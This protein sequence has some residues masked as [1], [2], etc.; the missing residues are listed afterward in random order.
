[1]CYSAVTL[2]QISVILVLSITGHEKNMKILIYLFD[3]AK[4][5]ST[6]IRVYIREN[7]NA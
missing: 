3:V 2:N 5:R 6:C 1:V 4:I 7:L